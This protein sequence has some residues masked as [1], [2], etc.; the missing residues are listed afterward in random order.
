MREIAVPETP[1]T[2]D[3]PGPERQVPLVVTERA[4]SLD[5]T[6]QLGFFVVLLAGLACILSAL[7]AACWTRPPLPVYVLGG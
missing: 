7:I 5:E 3:S 6:L 1:I 4:R 2:A